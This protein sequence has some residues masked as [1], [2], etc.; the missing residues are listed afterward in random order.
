MAGRR[1][2][3]G[4]QPSTR[5]PSQSRTAVA[6]ELRLPNGGGRLAAGAAGG[7]LHRLLACSVRGHFKVPRA[8]RERPRGWHRRG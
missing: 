8:T 4:N 3:D 5:C 1:S 6:A 2:E 7:E